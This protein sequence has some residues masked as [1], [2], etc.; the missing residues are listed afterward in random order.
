MR[1]STYKR[2]ETEG[3]SEADLPES[4]STAPSF[5]QDPSRASVSVCGSVVLLV[6]VVLVDDR[7]LATSLP[8]SFHP[9]ASLVLPD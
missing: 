1:R 7:P 8:T 6:V 3:T 5:S 4:S 9:P 2:S